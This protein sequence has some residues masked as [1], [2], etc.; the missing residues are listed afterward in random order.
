MADSLSAA[1]A[2]AVL[3]SAAM[4]YPMT[5]QR[6]VNR[7]G[8]KEGDYDNV[9]AAHALRVNVDRPAL[10]TEEEFRLSVFPHLVE[11]LRSYERSYGLLLGD[12]R[13]LERDT[14]DEQA[15][16]QQISRQTGIDADIV[17]GVL[18][19]YLGT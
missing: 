8:L 6:F 7:N 14:L 12:L 9:P 4:G 5:W 10:T 13:R 15:V 11:R 16:A 18:K 2:A 17:A 3:R 1:E 19:E